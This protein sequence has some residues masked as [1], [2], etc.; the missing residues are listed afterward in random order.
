MLENCQS[1]KERWGGVNNIIDRW[2][3]ERQQ[4]LVTYCD[5]SNVDAFTE[6]NIEH[7]NQLKKLCQ[8]LVDYVSAG[9]FEVYEQ[10]IK[11]GRDF[12]DKAGLKEAADLYKIID[13]T[14]EALLDFND[15]YQE[16]DDLSGLISDLS[17][18]GQSL[19]PRFS[20]EDKMIEV[21]HTSHKDMVA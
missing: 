1:A 21:L 5:L 20:A 6:E 19:E 18:M 9:H 2:L 8:I 10:L 12:N 4:L 13:N 16:T 17:Q 7:Q 15:K 14:T 11:E 3:H